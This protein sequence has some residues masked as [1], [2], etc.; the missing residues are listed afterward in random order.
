MDIKG[1]GTPSVLQND[2]SSFYEWAK[3]FEDHLS[4]IEPQLKEMLDWALE[5]E[6]EIRQSMIV[7]K[8]GENGDPTEQ[9]DGHAQV[10]VHL[11]TVLAHSTEGESWSVVHNFGRNGSLSAQRITQT[12]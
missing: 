7:D 12:C 1:V 11:K 2:K 3:K 8:F 4:G 10:V 9:V 6:C 5:N